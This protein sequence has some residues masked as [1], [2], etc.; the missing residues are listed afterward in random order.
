MTKRFYFLWAAVVS[1]ALCS[2]VSFCEESETAPPDPRPNAEPVPPPEF[3]TITTI[4]PQFLPGIKPCEG[5]QPGSGNAFSNCQDQA[6]LNR[7]STK[8]EQRDDLDSDLIV[9]DLVVPNGNILRID[10]QRKV[11]PPKYSTSKEK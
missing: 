5:S 3:D 2:T 10:I 4:K 9:D 6:T 1:G 8:P 7:I 11:V